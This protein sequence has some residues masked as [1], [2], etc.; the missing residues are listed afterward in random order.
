M[1]GSY[2]E[3]MP[4]KIIFILKGKQIAAQ[5]R[6]REQEIDTWFYTVYRN[7]EYVLDLDLV[8]K[9]DADKARVKY[10]KGVPES[11]IEIPCAQ[12]YPKEKLFEWIE[13]KT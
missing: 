6:K 4:P 5:E 8:E 2:I 7:S 13:Q 1:T 11:Y 12:A 9:F 10:L 3:M